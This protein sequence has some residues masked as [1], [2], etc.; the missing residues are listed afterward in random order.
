[1]VITETPVEERNEAVQEELSDET[2]W[3]LCKERAAQL[4]VPAWQI[5]E[6]MPWH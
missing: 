3:R 2:I 1:M 4:H 5:A 6:S